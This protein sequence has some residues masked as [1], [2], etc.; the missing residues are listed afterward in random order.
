M[1]FKKLLGIVLVIAIVFTSIPLSLD[2][3]SEINDCAFFGGN[4]SLEDPYLISTPQQLN[5]V[6][7]DLNACY[8]LINDIDMSAWGEW[9]PIG[10]D[11]SDTISYLDFTGSFNGGNYEIKNLTIEDL[12][13]SASAEYY[14]LFGRLNGFVKNVRLSNIKISLCEDD[15]NYVYVGGICGSGSENSSI[16]YCCT[17][18]SISVSYGNYVYAGGIL[19]LGNASNCINS[20]D[21]SVSAYN[22]SSSSTYC[23][24]I[25][26]HPLTVNGLISVCTNFGSIS[27]YAKGFAYAGGI[28]GQ[29]GTIE[30]CVNFGEII[31]ETSNGNVYSSFAKN[32]NAGGIVGATSSQYVKNCVN[33]GNTYSYALWSSSG[34]SAASG[35]IAGY[36]GYYSSGEILNCVNIAHKIDSIYMDYK[37]NQQIG[38]SGRIAGH[39]RKTSN[40]YSYSETLL[41]YDI[42]EK[43]CLPNNKQ[44][45]SCPREMLFTN[46]VY[47]DFD[48]MNLWEINLTYGGAVLK[49]HIES[50]DLSVEDGLAIYSDRSNLSFKKDT[51]ITIG[52]AIYLDGERQE[53]TSGITFSISDTSILTTNYTKTRDNCFFVN[54]KGVKNGTSFLTFSDSKTGYTS[55]IPITVYEGDYLS[56]TINSVPIQNIEKYETNFYN[57]N[58]LYIDSYDY[59]I[60]ENGTVDITFDAY[61]SNYIY[62]AVEVYNSSGKMINAAVIDKMT[63][64]AGSIKAAIWDNAGCLIRD[65][66]DGDL[67]TYRQE[68]GFTKKT[69]VNITDI[70]KDGYIKI[71]TDPQ[72]S[73]LVSLI[74]SVDILMSLGSFVGDIKD[75]DTNSKEF[76]E[77]LT[78]KLVN[79]AIFAELVK[80]GD[81]ASE[82]LY[83]NLGK[84]F[85][86]T[87]D[88]L[89]N[90]AQTLSNNLNNLKLGEL[91]SSTAWDMGWNVGENVFTFFAGPIGEVLNGMFAIGDMANIIMEKD[92]YIKSTGTQG[93]TI[94]NQGG[95]IR[96]TS[97]ITVKSQTDFTD[98]TALNVF[99]V[100]PNTELLSLFKA[101]SPE[102]YEEYCGGLTHTYNISMIK[103][104]EETQLENEV[105]V[106]I[107]IPDNLKILA[108]T[109][110]VKVYRVEEDNTLT[111]MNVDIQDGCLVFRTE[112][113]S[114]YTIIGYDSNNKNYKLDILDYSYE[115]L[116]DGNIKIIEYTGKD[117]YIKVPN[118]INGYL[119]T[120]L[121]SNSFAD[122]GS[123]KNILIPDSIRII[124][125]CAF[126]KCANLESITIPNSII[127]IGDGAFDNCDNLTIYCNIGNASDVLTTAGYEHKCFGDFDD[128]KKLSA[129]DIVEMH[130]SLL[131]LFD[132]NYDKK[133][134]DINQ[135]N[136]FNILDLVRLKKK[137]IGIIA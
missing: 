44:G 107:Q 102:L 111:E 106:Y 70:P 69:T 82:T 50:K 71:T 93:I 12:E 133:V 76:T 29:D 6:R 58:G 59:T 115:V 95:G 13:T 87:T 64:N 45:E 114:L 77:K 74:N 49:E 118:L 80:D 125:D 116:N 27:A 128:D 101:I 109:G 32:A 79:E 126:N 68:S 2:A 75:F 8:L 131:G 83:K 117:E 11:V 124:D 52:V 16:E 43:D 60:N 67:L 33:Y 20:I 14:G 105:D 113:F 31:A 61:N 136:N 65:V 94:Q 62:G 104:G 21:I 10:T 35:G 57:F 121:S 55:K 53:D 34:A 98:D 36:C 123:L 56:F 23:G 41:N 18:G 26:G 3:I 134:A 135:D 17:D 99:K 38:L 30:N 46:D 86:A 137:L 100:D 108:Y 22:G 25:V 54:L 39:S 28:C 63:N 9:I 72:N 103:K 110:K 84:E 85:L 89:G 78:F 112:H 97:Q 40:S 92:D 5:A 15:I 90:F 119:V 37:E 120:S 127:N 132:E 66:W 73:F 122:N 91:I 7:N 42:S 88:S 129:T 96:A 81:K 51:S 24:G 48:F 1:N 19:G 4:G 130:K 47:I